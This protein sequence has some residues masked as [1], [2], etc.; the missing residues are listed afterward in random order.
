MVYDK[1]CCN[2]ECTCRQFYMRF[3]G[4]HIELRCMEGHYVK[5]VG[6]EKEYP[7]LCQFENVIDNTGIASEVA[8][9]KNVIDLNKRNLEDTISGDLLLQKDAERKFKKSNYRLPQDNT[10]NQ[11]KQVKT[12]TTNN[13]DYSILNDLEVY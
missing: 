11:S 7:K 5:N 8:K 1:K 2:P 10:A 9:Y 4:Y 12:G 13:I 6:R 3:T